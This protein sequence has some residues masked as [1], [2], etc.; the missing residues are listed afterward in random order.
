LPP[1]AAGAWKNVSPDHPPVI[2]DIL[3]HIT[4]HGDRCGVV[5]KMARS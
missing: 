5:L 3:R 1:V 2:A 4:Y